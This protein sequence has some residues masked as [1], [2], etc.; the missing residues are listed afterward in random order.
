M[1]KCRFVELE[2]TKD[3]DCDNCIIFW[4]GYYKDVG[5]IKNEV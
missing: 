5:M 2:C 4:Y 1:I 3:H